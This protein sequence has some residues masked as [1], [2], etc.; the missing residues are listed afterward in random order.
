MLNKYVYNDTKEGRS[1]R[2]NLDDWN[3]PRNTCKNLK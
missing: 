3:T 1:T 2:D